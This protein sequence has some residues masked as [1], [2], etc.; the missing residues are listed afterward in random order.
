MVTN[1]VFCGMATAWPSTCF[2]TFGRNII[3]KLGVYW[4]TRSHRFK[5]HVIA[6]A[7][8]ISDVLS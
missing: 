4:A 3:S 8:K 5:A 7:L 6:S 2:Q 1:T